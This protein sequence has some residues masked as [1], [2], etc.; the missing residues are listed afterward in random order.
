MKPPITGKTRVAGVVGQPIVQSLSPL[1]HNAWL[2]AAGI[3]GVYVA[4]A[5]EEGRFG[6]FLD[7]LRGGVVRGLNV[8]MPF[9]QAALNA[10]DAV[11]ERAAKAS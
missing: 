6:S 2:E 1:I 10:A 11:T 4:L 8:T 9:K 5:P 7:G 3:D